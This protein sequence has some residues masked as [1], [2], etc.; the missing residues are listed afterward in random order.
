[1][2]Y[3]TWSPSSA[4]EHE[5]RK[6]GPTTDWRHP[7]IDLIKSETFLLRVALTRP[8]VPKDT[9]PLLCERLGLTEDIGIG[10]LIV[11]GAYSE[12]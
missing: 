7:R 8:L 2:D 1:V 9:S 5:D 12:T 6:D 4:R 3:P 11:K 10:S